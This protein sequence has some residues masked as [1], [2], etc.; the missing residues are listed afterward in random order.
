MTADN[1]VR[2]FYK[3]I[4]CPAFVT[5]EFLTLAEGQGICQN[6][7]N[8]YCEVVC[9]PRSE[10]VVWQG[11]PCG[12]G[13]CPPPRFFDEDFSV[14][15][16]KAI[17]AEEARRQDAAEE[18]FREDP[19]HVPS[20]LPETPVPVP[21]EPEVSGGGVRVNRACVV[22]D[23]FLTVGV[24]VPQMP[25]EAPVPER[26]VEAE[27]AQ[28]PA[29][30]NV[31]GAPADAGSGQVLY[32]RNLVDAMEDGKYKNM[33]ETYG[34]DLRGLHCQVMPD[35]KEQ[36]YNQED[37]HRELCPPFVTSVYLSLAKGQW[38]CESLRDEYFCT[39]AC[40]EGVDKV[41]WAAHQYTNCAKNDDNCPK[42]PPVTPV[43]EYKVKPWDGTPWK[44]MDCTAPAD[45]M[46]PVTIMMLVRN[47][48][49]SL[50]NTLRSYE[51]S[52]FLQ[53][54]PEFL[55]WVNGMTPDIEEVV[56]EFK[57]YKIK[58]M[59]DTENY[60]ITYPLNWMVGNA[61]HEHVLFLE[62]GTWK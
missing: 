25:A 54:I 47:E 60:G 9:Q 46:P 20:E 52:G 39:A 37:H 12:P 58:V 55:L 13:S 43:D 18:H 38:S 15:K 19:I 53:V 21:V 10:T 3:N 44:G 16:G 6:N 59:G 40:Q 29:P 26:E 33:M 48:V 28:P 51:R 7:A 35:G 14:E 1:A 42:R 5:P 31:G 11:L 57:R 8:Y 50:R 24:E 4:K 32:G 49:D 22:A 45:G 34:F 61:T 2:C 23:S 41:A 27:P 56:S 62:K 30:V 36:C 17:E